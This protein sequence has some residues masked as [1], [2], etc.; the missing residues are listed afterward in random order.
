ELAVLR[1]EDMQIAV[2]ASV[3]VFLRSL[4]LVRVRALGLEVDPA[5]DHPHLIEAG[6]AGHE[7][8]DRVEEIVL[9]QG[10]DVGDEAHG[11]LAR[12]VPP[13]L[14]IS[15]V[16]DRSARSAS[17]FFRLLR[18][19]V[20]SFLLSSPEHQAMGGLIQGSVLE[21][22]TAVSHSGSG[23]SSSASEGWDST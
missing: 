14:G 12:L 6:L 23:R 13:L 4:E 9:L 2:L 18:L 22:W 1:L 19:R 20:H 15:A 7:R 3:L 8:G 5:P 10:R 16:Q 11:L 21:S 17:R